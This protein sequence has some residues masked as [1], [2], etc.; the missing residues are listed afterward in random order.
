MNACYA[1]NVA[2]SD[3]VFPDLNYEE[4]CGMWEMLLKRG[5]DLEVQLDWVHVEG[6]TGTANWTAVYTFGATG[7][8]VLNRVKASFEFEEGKI[9]RHRD[10]FSFYKW[11]RQA[12][13]PSGWLLGATPFLKNKVQ[14]MARKGLDA[15]LAK[16]QS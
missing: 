11:A 7:R 8:K 3:P 10:E 6:D 15:H 5:K 13:G 2:F 1:E 14:R 16:P 4:V 9:V 12:F